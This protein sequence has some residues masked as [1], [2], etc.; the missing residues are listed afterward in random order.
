M[1]PVLL[2]AVVVNDTTLRDGEQAP[3]VAFSIEEK[4]AIARALDEAG[5]DEI[6]AGTPAM[7]GAEIEAMAAVADVLTQAEAIAWCR[8]TEA[9]LDAA[10]RTGLS[11]VNLSVPLSD[12]QIRAK[13][14]SDRADVLRRIDRVVRLARDLGFEVAV[15]GEDAS[16]ADLGFVCQAMQKAEDAGARRFRFADTLGILDPFATYAITRRLCAETDMEIEFHGH[17]DLGL[18]TANTL[19]AVQGGANHASVCVL[20]LGERAGNAALEEVVAAL[21]QTQG[22]RTNVDLTRL[23]GL[24]DMV[25]AAA[26][27]PIPMAKSI[28]GA[29]VFTHESGIHVHGLLQDP[30]TYEALSPDRFGR[31]REIVLGKHSGLSAIFAALRGLGLAAD[32]CR[33]RA[34]LAEVRER[35]GRTK[36]IVGNNDLLEIYAHCA[37]PGTLVGAE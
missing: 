29:G 20:G 37:Q 12:L 33:A 11:R 27:R 15:G 2:P 30:A 16:R 13:Y 26:C 23:Q 32:E 5:V 25:S 35:A 14:H 24:A 7:G 18:A 17:D 21:A 4:L 6:E 36:R 28:V 8:M 1:T 19:A 31:T 3:G 34:V 22:R 9:D 10:R